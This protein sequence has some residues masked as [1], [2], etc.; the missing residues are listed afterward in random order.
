M[1]NI[2]AMKNI[3]MTGLLFSIAPVLFAQDFDFH[4]LDKL[5]AVAKSSTNVTL[6]ANMLKL[7]AGFMGSD[8]DKD[9]A[10]I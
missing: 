6:D 1:K 4:T 3:L 8:N 5:A 2:L 10:S 9:A 7:A